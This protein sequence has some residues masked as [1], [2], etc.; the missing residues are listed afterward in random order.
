MNCFE[1]TLNLQLPHVV[2]LSLAATFSQSSCDL[3]GQRITHGSMHLNRLEIRGNLYGCW[4]GRLVNLCQIALSAA[5]KVG[6][7]LGL[8]MERVAGWRCVCVAGDL[9][10][11]GGCGS[12]FIYRLSIYPFN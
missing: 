7:A 12:A 1:V 5:V 9:D 11:V 6:Q 3:G 4:S 10:D 8:E 2:G